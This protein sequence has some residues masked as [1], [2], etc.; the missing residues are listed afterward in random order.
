M[1]L[2]WGSLKS[3]QSSQGLTRGGST[4]KLILVVVGRL[5]ETPQDMAADSRLCKIRSSY[6]LLVRA[7]TPLSDVSAVSSAR[8]HGILTSRGEG[9]VTLAFDKT[10]TGKR[11]GFGQSH[12]AGR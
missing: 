2:A 9:S 7:P 8:F 11:R 12:P 1:V 10:V 3:L 5:P 6:W 4:S